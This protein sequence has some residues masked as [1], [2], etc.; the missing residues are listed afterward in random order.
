VQEATLVWLDIFE[1]AI[2]N[3]VKCAPPLLANQPEE[4]VHCIR[5]IAGDEAQFDL[6]CGG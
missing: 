4:G 3:N 5:G 2:D 6:Q 1:L